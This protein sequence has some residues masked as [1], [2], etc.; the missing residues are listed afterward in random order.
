VGR[1]LNAGL[2][3]A[4]LRRLLLGMQN[5]V[6]ERSSPNLS[7]P[8]SLSWALLVYIIQ[9]WNSSY[10]FV[11]Y[12]DR[13]PVESSCWFCLSSPDVESH[14]VISIG[15]G[16][17]CALAK[18]PL[19]PE[20]VLVIPVEHFP[21]TITMPAEPEAELRRYKNALGKYFEKQGKTAVYFE[22]VSQQ[23]RHANLQVMIPLVYY[24]CSISH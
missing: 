18:G 23:S 22:W 13:R 5:P 3:T 6:G 20:H 8:L 11:D 19:V 12:S 2:L 16:Y 4:L 17:Y 15:D 10:I 9:L 24:H 14:L 1:A 7:L 21:T